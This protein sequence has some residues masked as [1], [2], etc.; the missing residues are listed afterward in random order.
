MPITKF[1]PSEQILLPAW[2]GP[3][4]GSGSLYS[5]LTA[6]P[7]RGKIQSTVQVAVVRGPP[8]KRGGRGKDPY[9]PVFSAGHGTIY[10]LQN[11]RGK[12][13]SCLFSQRLQGKWMDF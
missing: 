7:A 8:N 11:F 3:V 1:F 12:T 10:T 4:H 2:E 9:A 6:F 5:A 13:E